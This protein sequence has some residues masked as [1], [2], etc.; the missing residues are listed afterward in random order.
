MNV[1]NK[2]RKVVLSVE[3]ADEVNADFSIGISLLAKM[4]LQYKKYA[5]QNA[6][7]FLMPDQP[8]DDM[9]LMKAFLESET[10]NFS[11]L[12]DINKGSVIV[13]DMCDT[14]YWVGKMMEETNEQV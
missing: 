6:P 1:K 5:I 12:P 13:C 2:T 14:E 4:I 9:P 11:L 3:Y 7:Q 8:I 10:F